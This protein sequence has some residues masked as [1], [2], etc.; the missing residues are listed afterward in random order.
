MLCLFPL[1][2]I[3]QQTQT[4]VVTDPKGKPLAGA[5]VL[6]RHGS[7]SVIT[8]ASGRFTLPHVAVGDTLLIRHLGHKTARLPVATHQGSIIRVAL[9]VD[10][11]VLQEV[12]IQT[13]YYAVPQERATGSFTHIDKELLNRSVSTNIL[14]RLEG[15]TN[16]LLFDRRNL[17]GEN[18]DGAP[19]LRVRG[20]STIEGNSAPLIVIDNFPYEGDIEHLN[21]NMVESVTVLRDAAAASIWGARAGNG[22]IVITTKL[23][24]HH[25]PAQVSFNTNVTGI[26]KPDLFYSQ[27]FLPS[28]TVMDIQGEL[29]A[30]GAYAERD[31]TYIPAYVELLIRQRDGQLSDHD[32]A[33]EV[34][35]M[36]RADLRKHAMDHLYQRGTK[37]QYALNAQGGGGGYR[38]AMAVGYDRNH[39]NVIGNSDDRISLNLRN[40]FDITPALELNAGIWHSA[41]GSRHNGFTYQDVGLGTHGSIYDRLVNEDGSAAAVSSP[42][43]AGY[44][45]RAESEGLLDWMFRPLDERGLRDF[46]G[47]G[48][49]LR[50]TGGGTYRFLDGFSLQASY[51]YTLGNT[52]GRRIHESESFHVRNLVNRYTQA[53]GSRIIPHGGILEY[54]PEVSDQSHNGRLQVNYNRDI[55]SGQRISL[56]GGTEMSQRI[57]ISDPGQTLYNYDTELWIGSARYDLATFHALRPIGSG[58][59]P[60]V[61]FS[62]F[63]YDNRFLSHFGNASY[64]YSERYIATASIRWDGSNL[65]GVK[66]NQRGTALW[67]AGGSWEIS[68]EPFYPLSD[69]LPYLRMRATYG[70]AGNI[71]HSQSQYPTIV[72]VNNAITNVRESRLTHPGNPSLR[73]ER[74]NTVNLGLDWKSRG[75]RVSGSMEY[76]DKRAKD[77]LGLSLMDPTTGIP[78]G[79]NYKMNYGTLRTRGWD[80][81]L[82]TR[83]I[84]GAF[85]WDSHLLL[86]HSSNSI[87]HYN[88]PEST[89]SQ[90]FTGTPLKEGHSV[91]LLYALPWY[92]LSPVNGMPLI[93]HEGALTDDESR[94]AG[95]FLNFPKEN[96]IVAGTRVPTISGSLRNTFSFA[97]LEVSALIAFKAGHVFRRGSIG[98]GQEYLDATPVYHTDYF[99]RWQRPGDEKRTHVPAWAPTPAPNQR[100][101]V[102]QNAEVLVTEGDVVRLQDVQFAYTLRKATFGRLPVKRVRLYAYARNPGIIWKANEHGIDPDYPNANYPAPRTY[103]CG[104]QVDF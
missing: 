81:Q 53:D 72:V 21:P 55:R 27:R 58:Q 32:F 23:G 103:S 51:Q 6:Y 18:V 102:Y 28:A 101:A 85:S 91:D 20:L 87:T 82:N 64:T 24:R 56:L 43:R 16:G 9:D 7:L 12:E 66:T 44:R 47:R 37:Q 10:S 52:G 98:P 60:S 40:S 75:Q 29:F 41:R 78:I 19:E 14:D 83:N 42:Y 30:R 48:T 89:V 86:N 13:G 79:G 25:Q 5:T 31:Q 39:A 61:S 84:V 8:D 100:F 80:L 65:L 4:G 96:L 69:R 94:Y 33:A 38:Y 2:G 36:E 17:S 49:E 46:T 15:V 26:E 93:M 95:Y 70:S 45:E 3:S 67:S 34:A 104:I 77:L 92:G 88:G 50:V 11:N 71:D 68:G 97:G 62:P 73:W 90:H 59:I 54:D 1:S 76:Y 63:R 57:R 99:K 35:M 22:V 74:V